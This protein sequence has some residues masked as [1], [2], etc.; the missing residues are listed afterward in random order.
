MDIGFSFQLGWFEYDIVCVICLIEFFF[1]FKSF[2]K[3]TIS[4]Q[5]NNK[6][7]KKLNKYFLHTIVKI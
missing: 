6:S 5:K 3:I 2:I 1:L 7:D 4:I